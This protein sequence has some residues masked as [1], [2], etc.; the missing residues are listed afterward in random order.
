MLSAEGYKRTTDSGRRTTKRIKP[1]G[2]LAWGVLGSATDGSRFSL[3][4]LLFSGAIDTL[5]SNLY[6][7]VASF[8]FFSQAGKPL[9]LK[10]FTAFV[11]TNPCLPRNFHT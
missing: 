1:I 8:Q 10:T 4:T 2:R 9:R 5:E 3:L 7:K 6:P 11:E